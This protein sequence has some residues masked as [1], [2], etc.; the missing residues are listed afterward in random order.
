MVEVLTRTGETVARALRLGEAL[1]ASTGL[2]APIPRKRRRMSSRSTHARI[3]AALTW[4]GTLGS[5]A[6]ERAMACRSITWVSEDGRFIPA[7]GPDFHLLREGQSLTTARSI[8]RVNTPKGEQSQRLTREAMRGGRQFRLV[9]CGARG[10]LRSWW[11]RKAPGGLARAL[12]GKSG[13]F[14]IQRRIITNTGALLCKGRFSLEASEVLIGFASGKAGS[15]VGCVILF[16]ELD[17]HGQ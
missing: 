17:F 12:R 9:G 8:G 10:W 6:L 16:G 15:G 3:W 2:G 13:L 5:L 7:R 11:E 4:D 1:R 14:T